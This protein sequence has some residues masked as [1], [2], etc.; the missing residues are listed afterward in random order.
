V[1]FVANAA[2]SMFFICRPIFIDSAGPKIAERARYYLEQKVPF[3]H[4]FSVFTTDKLYC[5]ELLFYIFREVGG[6]NVFVVEKKH[7]SY[8]LMFET[9]FREENFQ[10]IFHLKELG[11]N[12]KAL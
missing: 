10:P 6:K 3:D 7:K 5:T 12:E 2:D 8:M 4:G 11:S 9:F 1:E